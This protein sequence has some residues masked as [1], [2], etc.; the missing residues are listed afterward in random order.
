L[1]LFNAKNSK[2]VFE[3]RAHQT[4][5]TRLSLIKR[6]N[7]DEIL[8]SSGEDGYFILWEINNQRIMFIKR[9]ENIYPITDFLYLQSYNFICLA[10]CDE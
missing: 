8:I 5:I 3:I 9:I 10:L 1:T 6:N 7:D 2:S 4:N